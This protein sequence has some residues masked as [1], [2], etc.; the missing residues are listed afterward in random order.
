MRDYRSFPV[1][2]VLAPIVKLSTSGTCF[3]R[4]KRLGLNGK[5]VEVLKN[6]TC[7]GMPMSGSRNCCEVPDSDTRMEDKFKEDMTPR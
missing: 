6:R 2:I 3:L 1:Y 7:T 4:A 5:T